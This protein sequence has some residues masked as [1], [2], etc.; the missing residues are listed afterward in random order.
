MTPQEFRRAFRRHWVA[1][2]LI[3]PLT[4]MVVGGSA[5][6]ADAYAEAKRFE[7]AASGTMAGYEGFTRED[8]DVLRARKI[9]HS[10]AAL[11]IVPF[12]VFGLVGCVA[13]IASSPWAGGCLVRSGLSGVALGGIEVL[14]LRKQIGSMWLLGPFVSLLGV[15]IAMLGLL[16]KRG[17]RANELPG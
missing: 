5:K 1:L 16:A 3:F 17:G 15:G 8:M 10:L 12:A 14:L 13:Q 4:A 11:L 7:E 9:R 2:A 6:A